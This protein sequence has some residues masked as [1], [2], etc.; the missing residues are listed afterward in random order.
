MLSSLVMLYLL[1]WEWPQLFRCELCLGSP[2][3]NWYCYPLCFRHNHHSY[4]NRFKTL[5]NSLQCIK[6]SYFS[7]LLRLSVTTWRQK[8]NFQ[9]EILLLAESRVRFRGSFW[10]PDPVSQSD[11]TG[12]GSSS[13]CIFIMDLVIKDKSLLSAVSLQLVPS[14]PR[15][16]L[17]WVCIYSMT[18]DYCKTGSHA[19][20]SWHFKSFSMRLA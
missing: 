16:W 20:W 14:S 13:V 17:F 1:S 9:D 2:F 15:L 6:N 11:W 5:D 10:K 12:A 3:R 7:L 4:C 18:T 19:F 8:I